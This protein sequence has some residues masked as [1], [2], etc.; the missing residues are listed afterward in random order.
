MKSFV[1]SLKSI[2]SN[3]GSKESVPKEYK[4]P[5]DE[6]ITERKM[7]RKSS[8]KTREMIKASKPKEEL[9]MAMGC[10]MDAI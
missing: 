4:M 1:N 8:A 9:G 6:V 7:K 2:G 5:K 3:F 10:A